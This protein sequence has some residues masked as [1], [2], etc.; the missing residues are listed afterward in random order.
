MVLAGKPGRSARYSCSVVAS[1]V[2]CMVFCDG[3]KGRWHGGC[4]GGVRHGAGKGGAVA[5]VDVQVVRG[6][7]GEGLHGGSCFWGWLCLDIRLI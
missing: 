7:E 5:Q 4:G 6:G 1:A 2:V 3:L